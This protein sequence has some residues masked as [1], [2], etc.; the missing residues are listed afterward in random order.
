MSGFFSSPWASATLSLLG[1]PWVL[2]KG[3]VQ[4]S[5]GGQR[6]YQL[7]TALDK[8]AEKPAFGTPLEEHLKRSGREIALPIEACVMLLLETGMKEEVRKVYPRF[9]L[10]NPVTLLCPHHH[11]HTL[12]FNSYCGGIDQWLSILCSSWPTFS[13]ES[14]DLY[15]VNKVGPQNSRH[16]FCLQCTLTS[17][18]PVSFLS[19]SVYDLGQCSGGQ[20]CPWSLV[21]DSLEL[22]VLCS[23]LNGY[24]YVLYKIHTKNTHLNQA[25][26]LLVLLT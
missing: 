10:P 25:G 2:W 23:G 13:N 18:H 3:N 24:I 19:S 5:W 9:S 11:P 22:C 8:W 6:S 14:T 4:N 20:E 16:L 12:S 1:S 21:H 7:F 26:P 17:N 15:S